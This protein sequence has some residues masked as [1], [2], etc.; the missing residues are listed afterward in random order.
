MTSDGCKLHL[1]NTVR[2]HDY[3]TEYKFWDLLS[4]SLKDQNLKHEL[5]QCEQMLQQWD[6]ARV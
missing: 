1:E 4:N 3:F 6:I 2:D 5:S